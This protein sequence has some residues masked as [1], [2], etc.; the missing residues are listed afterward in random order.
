[1]RIDAACEREPVTRESSHESCSDSDA[2][3]AKAV[4]NLKRQRIFLLALDFDLTIV[5]IHT[6]GKWRRDPSELAKHVRPFWPLLIAEA[7]AEGICVAVVTMSPQSDLI[8]EVLLHI[9]P[10]DLVKRIVIRGSDGSWQ[11]ARGGQGCGK[12]A[13][14]ASALDELKR[15]NQCTGGKAEGVVLVDD[16]AENVAAAT[17]GAMHA[18][19]CPADCFSGRSASASI[20]DAVLSSLAVLPHHDGPRPGVV[21][22]PSPPPSP[23]HR[24]MATQSPT[25]VSSFNGTAG[26]ATPSC[27]GAA[28]TQGLVLTPNGWRLGGGESS[29]VNE[30]SQRSSPGRIAAVSGSLG[31]TSTAQTYRSPLSPPHS[32]VHGAGMSSAGRV[33]LHGAPGYPRVALGTGPH[34]HMS[35]LSSPGL[36]PR[37]HSPFVGSPPGSPCGYR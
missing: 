24:S 12:Q 37:G 4:A 15:M 1:M 16:D 5:D 27:S 10:M 29:A 28:D 36:L 11:Q 18:V 34:G 22:H 7:M 33:P 31:L 17:R 26:N 9:L 32:P 19:W 20:S 6:G 3:V 21:H 30:S 8:H 23:V 13:H 2:A 25:L 14:I 35:G